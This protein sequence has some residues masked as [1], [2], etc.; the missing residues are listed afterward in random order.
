MWNWCSLFFFLNHITSKSTKQVSKPEFEFTNCH[1]SDTKWG[2]GNHKG[3][4][5]I[6]VCKT[7]QR[8]L[9]TTN[10]PKTSHG[11][12]KTNTHVSP[13]FTNSGKKIRKSWKS[14]KFCVKGMALWKKPNCSFIS[15]K[16]FR[17]LIT[18]EE[19]NWNY[20]P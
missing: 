8:F 12:R 15:K 2:M 20:L 16:T 14:S 6:R 4:I 13:I 5:L 7:K 3:E 9:S 10:F 11:G 17:I 19:R 18:K 1:I